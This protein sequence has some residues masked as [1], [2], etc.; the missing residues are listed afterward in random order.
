[1]TV[2]RPMIKYHETLGN[3]KR[4]RQ[5]GSGYSCIGRDE[6]QTHVVYNKSRRKLEKKRKRGKKL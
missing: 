3:E 4:Q 5:S 6:Q 1:M 2:L